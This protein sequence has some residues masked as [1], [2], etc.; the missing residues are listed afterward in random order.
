[1]YKVSLIF[2][3]ALIRPAT[4]TQAYSTI[5]YESRGMSLNLGYI[6][7]LDSLRDTLG[8]C[9]ASTAIDQRFS[10]EQKSYLYCSLFPFIALIVGRKASHAA[11]SDA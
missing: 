8:A 5:T 2:H 10:C 7:S 4:E 1:M 3:T 9:T 6:L 11:L